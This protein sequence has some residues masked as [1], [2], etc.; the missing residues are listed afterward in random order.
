[1][2]T[3]INRSDLQF[4]PSER[5]SDNPDGG[6]LALGTPILDVA[7]AV[8]TP[9]SSVARVNGD[10]NTRLIYAGVLRADDEPL[11][12]AHV[13][14]TRP[15]NDESVSY[16]LAQA[17][18]GESRKTAV[19]RMESYNVATIESAMT[20]LSNPAKGSKVIQVY[21]RTGEKLPQ[22]GDVYCLKQDKTGYPSLEQYIQVVKVDAT[23]RV[24]VQG[25]REFNR[26]V[27]KLELSQ[28]LLHEFVG[29]DYP[30]PAYANAPTKVCETH[31]ADA[32][33]YYGVKPIVKAIDKGSASCQVASIMEKVVPTATVETILADQFASPQ[34]RTL[35]DSANQSIS[36]A[37]N[38][39]VSSALLLPIV[40]NSL[41]IG[42]VTDAAGQLVRAGRVIGRV[43]YQDGVIS[44][45]APTHLGVAR[46]KPATVNVMRCDSARIDID[47]NNRSY[48]HVISLPKLG[49]G[50]LRVSYMAQSKWYTLTDDGNG[51]LVGTGSGSINYATALVTVTCAEMP[52]V[53]SAIVF[54]WGNAAY[55][56]VRHDAPIKLETTP[57]YQ[58]SDYQSLSIERPSVDGTEAVIKVADSPLAKGAVELIFNATLAIDTQG[59]LDNK[60]VAT[61][62]LYDDGQG[63]LNNVAGV[64]VGSVN[65]DT[66]TV[67]FKLHSA[68][69]LLSP[70]Y[71]TESYTVRQSRN[72]F[73]GPKYIT[74]TR[75]VY[76]GFTPSPAIAIF[77]NKQVIVNYVLKSAI[78]ATTKT[79]AKLE[80]SAGEHI[81]PSSLVM[82]VDDALCYDKLGILYTHHNATTGLG[83][84]VGTVDYGLGVISF[85][86][87]VS[88]ISLISCATSSDDITT[89]SISFATPTSPIRP[90]SLQISAIMADGTP[91]N[92]IA[93]ADGSFENE[94][95]TGM[96]DVKTGLTTLDFGDWV[97]ASQVQDMPWF[98]QDKVVDGR[99]WQSKQVIA[100]SVKY[101]AVA[102]SHLSLGEQIKIDT[103]RLPSDGRVPIFRRGDTIL[104]GNRITTDI[105]SAHQSGQTVQ[106]PRQHLDRICVMDS[107]DKPVLATLWDYD[108][109][110]GTI[111]WA[112][113]LDLS[114]YKLPIKVMHAQEEKNRVTGVD[115]D[116]TLSLMFALKHDYP[117]ENT[118]VS[119]VLL[120]GDLQVRAS[121]P[122]TQKHWDNVWRD[123]P[124]GAE[125]LNR[126]N[127]K[128]YPIV[129]TDDG[130][131]TEKWL[132]KFT[133]G[134]QFE[135]YGETLGFVVKTDTLQNLAPTN[136]STGKPYFTIDKRAFGSDAPWASQDVIRFNTWGT[137]L[138]VWIIRAVQPT[139]TTQ[140]AP[141]GFTVCLFGDTVEI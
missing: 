25:E 47:V 28:V 7:N 128:D 16:L 107:N 46:F 27:I 3:K 20:L 57:A 15:P 71:V 70:S 30:V 94:Y 122:F 51:K 85:K 21:Q 68:S 130:A 5:L 48:N 81:V 74:Q 24:F 112:T 111:T 44:L 139:S 17:S 60:G 11:I 97:E 95:V 22:V 50:S 72:M 110:A 121:V 34:A 115:I 32:G 77:D 91:V 102:I 120:G 33:Q 66:A 29:A 67:R 69:T 92:A 78:S 41:T 141:D 137:L 1:M 138:P 8:F 134:N 106:L 100:S 98:H 104:I 99:I 40:P 109:D 61:V 56:Q 39:T 79:S 19:A 89:D 73:R 49:A 31:V 13:A 58:D 55:Q 18:F 80:L 82:M 35:S 53:G 62:R 45:D 105:G 108:L 132:I 96:I 9:I 123:V 126:L 10:F 83:V 131:I 93:K 101:N 117:I 23:E 76:A 114:G 59:V 118:Y 63:K 113:P 64:T 52:D 37:I 26:V 43:N 135:L 129:L 103:V 14:L 90:N 42:D 54:N 6:G 4:Y 140:D 124:N 38:A 84:A 136:P 125:L 36:I 127:V 87:S 133:S 75:E 88:S 2:T 12:G 119:S 116:G 86:N 65:Y